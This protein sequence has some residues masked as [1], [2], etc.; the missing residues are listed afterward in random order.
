MRGPV[1]PV[2]FV[3]NDNSCS[4]VRIVPQADSTPGEPYALA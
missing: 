1:L 3:N 2:F 4:G